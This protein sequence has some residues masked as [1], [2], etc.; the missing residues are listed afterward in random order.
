MNE[1]MGREIFLFKLTFLLSF[2]EDDREWWGNPGAAP[3]TLPN[4]LPC[5]SEYT[6]DSPFQYRVAR[7]CNTLVASL[8]MKNKTV[9]G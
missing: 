1:K 6:P 8:K 4:N 3:V 5:K 9:N 2:Y 7:K